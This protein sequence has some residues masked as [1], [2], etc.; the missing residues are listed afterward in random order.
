MSLINEFFSYNKGINNVLAYTLV[1]VT[2]YIYLNQEKKSILDTYYYIFNIIFFIIG[3]LIFYNLFKNNVNDPYKFN[4]NFELAITFITLICL[5]IIITTLYFV[6]PGN[7]I[8]VNTNIIII[9]GIFSFVFFLL[10]LISL[11]SLTK[12]NPSNLELFSQSKKLITILA[13]ITLSGLLITWIALNLTNLNG[14]YKVLYFIGNIA[15]ILLIGILLLRLLKAIFPSLVKKQNAFND[16]IINGFLFI[17]CIIN[18]LLDNS[19]KSKSKSKLATETTKTPE[20]TSKSSFSKFT[21]FFSSFSNVI[22]KNINF[23]TNKQ[24]LL[25]LF[26]CS[27]ITII[28]LGHNT[29][30]NIINKQGGRQLL[31]GPLPL[32]IINNLGTYQDLN[33]GKETYDYT[34]ALSFWIYINSN[35]PNT[36]INY[37]KPTSLLNFANKPNIY[38]DAKTNS[39]I[40]TMEQKG[41]QQTIQEKQKSDLDNSK[42]NLNIDFSNNIIEFDAYGNRIIYIKK[43]FL[44]Q[45]WNNI[46]I[47]YN[48]GTLDIFLNGELVKS[49]IG[50]VPYYKLDTI[51]TGEENGIKGGISNIIYFNHP[52]NSFNVYFLYYMLREK[53]PPY[54]KDKKQVLNTYKKL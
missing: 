36:N 15:L 50:I 46:I 19:K 23:E 53:S 34:Y 9:T 27:I 24:I 17:P 48:S 25:I 33:N 1:L 39:L 38:Y 6:N 20:T 44:L 7:S 43:N 30:L 3:I 40:I 10:L 11:F 49:I 8:K 2:I 14:S 32:N 13:S 22:N 18:N 21:S 35:S 12:N 41:L 51:T 4:I 42:N 54:F 31:T 16:L 52:V 47:N 29:L 28:Y 26:I 45:K 37:S 5:I